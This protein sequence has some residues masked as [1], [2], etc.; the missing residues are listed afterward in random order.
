M[1]ITILGAG[2]SGCAHAF[3]FTENGHD[4][5]LLKTSDS[6]HEENYNTIKRNG[7]IWA[8]DDTNGGRKSFQS[9][10]RITK[11]IQLALSDAELIV[12]LTQSLQHSDIEKKI[13]LYIQP[14]TKMIL[15]IPGNLGSLYFKKCLDKNIILS[16][17]E[18]TPFDARIV[19]PG[20]VNILFKNARNALAFLP[21]CRKNEGLAIVSSLV[22][23]YKYFRS[24][25]IESS[26]HN[27]NLVVHTV[28]VIMSANRIEM[29]NGEFWM[30]KE[31]FSPSIWRLIEQLDDEKNNLIE[32]FGGERISY[33]DACKFRNEADLNRNSLEVFLS[34]AND[35]GPKGPSSL[36][37][38]YLY[39]DVSVGLCTL[40]I[41]GRKFDIETP[42]T[43]A[44]ITIASSLVGFDFYSKSRDF[45]TFFANMTNSEIINFINS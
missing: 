2:N 44:L 26:L 5:T 15:L 28:G 29:T 39:E 16:E 45:D 30:Y 21:S 17:G 11:D 31:S 14:C 10:H 36:D 24:N 4:V 35:G 1:K 34:Y 13:A 20:T 43:N 42:V 27:P 9:L 25:I 18:S 40:S 23:T 22:D 32:I 3:K 33:L 6:L 7:G 12:I 38:R 8:I 37:T 41:L 19:E